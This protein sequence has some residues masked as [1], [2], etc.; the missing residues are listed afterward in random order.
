MWSKRLP[1]V[2]LLS[3]GDGLVAARHLFHYGYQPAIYYPKR[4]KNELYEVSESPLFPFDQIYRIQ[5]GCRYCLSASAQ[6]DTAQERRDKS[7]S[8]Q[9]HWLPL[10]NNIP[11][12][13]GKQ[14]RRVWWAWIQSFLSS[15]SVIRGV[16]AMSFSSIRPQQ[17]RSYTQ[18]PCINMWRDF[19]RIRHLADFGPMLTCLH[20][21]SVWSNNVKT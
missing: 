4:P 12:R 11:Y 6:G 17:A 20:L 14:A 9:A 19:R 3:G 10:K 16:D 21:C 15:L 18:S 8:R 7:C 2:C 5:R 13:D 1:V